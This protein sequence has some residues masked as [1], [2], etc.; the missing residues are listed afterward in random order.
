M[1]IRKNIET[2]T[3]LRELLKVSETLTERRDVKQAAYHCLINMLNIRAEYMQGIDVLQIW[4][5][6]MK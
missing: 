4:I 2:E 5:W 3:N 1:I 6:K